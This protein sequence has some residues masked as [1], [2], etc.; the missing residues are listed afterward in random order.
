MYHLENFLL[1]NS[2]VLLTFYTKYML[3]LSTLNCSLC[4]EVKIKFRSP[5]VYFMSM[6]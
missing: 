2:V 5:Y 6:H 3:L 4:W 1:V